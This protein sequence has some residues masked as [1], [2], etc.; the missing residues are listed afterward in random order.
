VFWIQADLSKNRPL[1]KFSQLFAQPSRYKPYE[2]GGPCTEAMAMNLTALAMMSLSVGLGQV[3]AVPPAPVAPMIAGLPAGVDVSNSRLHKLDIEYTA[4]QK[5]SIKYIELIVSKDQGQT[6][7]TVDAVSPDK[8]HLNF[9]AKDDGLYYLNIVIVFKDGKRDPASPAL[10]N[11]A[12]KMLVDSTVPVVRMN[13]VRQGEDIAVEWVIEDQYINDAATQVQYKSTANSLGEWVTVPPGNLSKNSTR[14]R[15]TVGGPLWVRVVAADFAGNPGEAKKEVLGGTMPPVNPIATTAYSPE[16]PA[17]MIPSGNSAPSNMV[18][19]APISVPMNLA[20]VPTNPGSPLPL[21]P[22]ANQGWSSASTGPTTPV[23]PA[24]MPVIPTTTPVETGPA[25]I[26]SSQDHA[27]TASNV[28]PSFIP[29]NV[30]VIRSPDFDLKYAVENTGPSGISRVDL[31]VTR[32]EGRSWV[33]WSTHDGKESPLKVKLSRGFDSNKEGDYGLK[34]VPISGVGLGDDVPT[35]GTPPDLRVRVDTIPPMIRIFP[36]T[37]AP[38]AVNA[39]V[40]NWEAR[41]QNF[42]ANPI[43]I[44]WSESLTGPWRSVQEGEIMPAGV[45]SA[46]R[47]LPN[48]GSYT[49]TLPRNLPTHRVYLRISAVDAA[50]NPSQAVTREPITVDLMKPKARIV[51]I[52]TP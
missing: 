1:A 33:K 51:T 7:S 15:P 37:V 6:W 19:P 40:L 48:T 26:G 50:G 13:A 18:M 38:N 16:T 8:D 46:N 47:G 44:D 41:D 52:S 20:P 34:L 27:S 42:G 28:A 49:W 23:T 2:D 14:F 35:A 45:S 4:E 3:P 22:A 10:D 5:K 9:Q 11:R 21:V 12:I 30:Q 24:P 25:A 43:S 31:Y 29:A 39:V 17:P 36:H 32:D